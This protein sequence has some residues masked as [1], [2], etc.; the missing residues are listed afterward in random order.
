MA[1][2]ELGSSDIPSSKVDELKSKVK[3]ALGIAQTAAGMAAQPYVIRERGGIPEYVHYYV[4]WRDFDG[5]DRETRSKIILDAVYDEFGAEHGLRTTVAMG[6]TPPEAA[7]LGFLSYKVEPTPRKTDSPRIEDERYRT[8]ADAE[9]QNTLMGAGSRE[10][11][12]ATEQEADAAMQRLLKALPGSYWS[13]A[14]EEKY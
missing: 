2:H 3:Q 6:L 8:A 1:I 5:V 11:R 13:V 14:K 7:G 12:Y 4:I 10:L 9:A